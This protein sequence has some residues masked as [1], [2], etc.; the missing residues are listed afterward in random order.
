MNGSGF[1]PG[2]ETE[3]DIKREQQQDRAKDDLVLKYLL[4]IRFQDNGIDFMRHDDN[5][6][7]KE[8]NGQHKQNV[9]N[10]PSGAGRRIYSFHY[11]P[12]FKS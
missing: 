12:F 6:V 1:P 2:K 5:H 8:K 10:D 9:T 7:S 4:I 11:F 3:T